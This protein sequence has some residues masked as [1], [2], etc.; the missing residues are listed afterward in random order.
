MVCIVRQRIALVD[1]YMGGNAMS[2][3]GIAIIMGGIVLQ[4]SN[5]NRTLEAQHET[6]KSIRNRIEPVNLRDE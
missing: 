4:L 1:D 6:M 2:M 3:I 5:I